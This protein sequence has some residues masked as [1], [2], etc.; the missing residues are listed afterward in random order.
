MEVGRENRADFKLIAKALARM[1]NAA[2]KNG[3]L[4]K[5]KTCYEKALTEHR[6]PEY[7]LALSEVTGKDYSITADPLGQALTFCLFVLFS[8]SSPP[9]RRKSK[10]TTSILN[11]PRPRN[12][13]ETRSLRPATTPGRSS[14]T[15][16]PSCATRPI[17]KFTATGPLVTPN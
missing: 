17:T 12:R 7:R 9:S 14:T 3:D 2:K 1:G 8:R 10:P 6:T 5:A 4:D 11:Y 16:R 15:P 13:K